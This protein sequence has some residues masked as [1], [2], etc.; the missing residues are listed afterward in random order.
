MSETIS[1]THFA[2]QLSQLHQT[3]YMYLHPH[4][5][6]ILLHPHSSH[7]LLVLVLLVTCT[8]CT[9]HSVTCTPHFSH[10][11]LHFSLL[12]SLSHLHPSLLTQSLPLLTPHTVTSTPPSSPHTVTST[13]PSS[14]NTVTSTP[15][16]SPRT[17]VD[18]TDCDMDGKTALHWAAE[19]G[20]E[21]GGR[22]VQLL[23]ERQ[24]DLVEAKARHACTCSFVYVHVQWR[25]C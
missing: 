3:C 18:I 15:P 14:P 10:I 17:Q 9:P 22:C 21:S 5:S 25:H 20:E 19:C 8:T 13:P 11:H 23:V 2:S 16:S 1:S 24:R 6:H 4:S 7:I 12:P